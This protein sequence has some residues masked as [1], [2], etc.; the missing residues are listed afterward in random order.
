MMPGLTLQPFPPVQ[1][2][3]HLKI[4]IRS[5]L[6]CG[7]Q[8]QGNH[9]GLSLPFLSIIVKGN[10]ERSCIFTA[11]GLEQRHFWGETNSY[12]R[13][14]PLFQHSTITDLML[15]AVCFAGFPEKKL[16]KHFFLLH[17]YAGGLHPT[18]LSSLSL[19]FFNSQT[20]RLV[21]VCF[22]LARASLIVC[23]D[24]AS[25]QLLIS[26]KGLWGTA[27]KMESKEYQ[28]KKMIEYPYKKVIMFNKKFD[29]VFFNPLAK[30][31]NPFR[32]SVHCVWSSQQTDLCLRV[33]QLLLK[34][35]KLSQNKTSFQ[36]M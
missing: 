16:Q 31:F 21:A 13:C 17:L 36:V 15:V 29:T 11:L 6:W 20:L 18:D 35:H 23:Q 22:H 33:M 5:P 14:L 2:E 27:N 24:K 4:W 3:W 25:Y 19:S 10:F 8:R 34:S 1:F 32:R 30:D 7:T 28:V 9:S 26:D 12:K